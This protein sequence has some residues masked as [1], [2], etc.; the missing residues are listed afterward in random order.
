MGNEMGNRNVSGL[1]G[2]VLRRYFTFFYLAIYI[3]SLHC[4][5][6]NAEED[7]TTVEAPE[8]SLQKAIDADDLKGENHIVPA[9]EDKDYHE[10]VK[11]LVSD[12]PSGAGD[13]H[14]D[15]QTSDGK[16]QVETE[17]QPSEGA[18]NVRVES[19]DAGG[20]H[21]GIQ[22]ASSSKGASDHEKPMESNLEENLSQKNGSQIEKQTSIKREEEEVQNSDFDTKSAPHNP[23]ALETVDPKFHQHELAKIHYDRSIE[24]HSGSSQG[25]E[26]MLG[27]KLEC[28][29]EEKGHLLETEIADNLAESGVSDA[30]SD[31]ETIRGDFLVKEMAS[32]EEKM[33]D[34]SLCEEK[35]EMI[36]Q[37][38]VGNDMNKL[39]TKTSSFSS[40]SGNKWDGEFPS[41]MNINRND[42]LDSQSEATLLGNSLN[43]NE[44]EVSETK[45]K[46]MVLTE[47][48]KLIESGFEVNGNGYNPIQFCEDSLEE[49]QSDK[50]DATQSELMMTGFSH[51]NEGKWKPPRIFLQCWVQ[52]GLSN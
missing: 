28:D 40:E 39:T 22:T 49:S 8:K 20:D 50:V 52:G 47:E 13:P 14:V 45:D 25:S 2:M 32:Q 46:C 31:A 11:E 5:W 30:N 7:H 48:T 24:G 1:Q 44:E 9:D 10:K 27:L 18:S 29:S 37:D 4:E 15:N 36:D 16:E 3:S 21:S 43:F 42:S 51:E 41:E 17:I 35:F 12:D 23:D 33:S 26:E 34:R 19:N 6:A 38:G